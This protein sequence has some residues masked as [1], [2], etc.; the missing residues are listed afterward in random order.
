MG[1]RILT[2]DRPTGRLHLGHLVGSLAQRVQLQN[3]GL[4]DEMYIEIADSQATTDNSGN[5]Q[6]VKDN[7]IEVALDYLSCGIDPKKCT[8]FLQSEV[9]ELSDLTFYYMNLVTV[10]RLQ[11]NPTVKQEIVYRGFQNTLPVGFM[12]YPISQAADITAFDANIIPVGDDQLPMI[13]QTREIVRTFNRLYGDTLVEPQA[14]LPQNTACHRLPG[15]DGQAKMSKSIGNCIYL[16]DSKEDVKRK[17]MG[18]F[19]DPNHLRVQDPGVTEGNPVFIYLSAFS[20]DKHF[21]EYFKNPETGEIE[22]KNLDE[23]KAHYE[24]GG[25]GDMKVK[26]FL[27]YVLEDTLA[28]IRAR[29]HELEKHIPEVYQILF[30]G[31]EKARLKAS[32][33]LAR[34]KAAIG[35][36]YRND[37]ELINSQVEKYAKL[38]A[39]SETEKKTR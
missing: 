14:I 17:V 25:L 7:V 4:Y 5:I 3:S 21:E 34:V 19:T 20:K 33:T 6:K 9:P 1:N 12:T 22:Y 15:T 38:H 16:S 11:R 8:I 39:S 27:N 26:K 24:R 23:L 13:E 37:Y 35:L 18:M 10:A 2:G 32:K 30:E 31:S 28:P 36:D 29:R